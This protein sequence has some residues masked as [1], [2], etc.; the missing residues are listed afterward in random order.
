MAKSW[1][2]PLVSLF[3]FLPATTPGSSPIAERVLGFWYWEHWDHYTYPGGIVFKVP[4][5]WVLVWFHISLSISETSSIYSVFLC[6]RRLK[7]RSRQCEYTACPF[8]IFFQCCQ[9]FALWM[10]Y[11]VFFLRHQPDCQTRLILQRKQRNWWFC[12]LANVQS[13]SPRSLIEIYVYCTFLYR[14][15]TTKNGF[16]QR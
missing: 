2:W 15:L 9:R 3:R 12:R 10:Y 6:V 16:H 5:L 1:W 7:E 14:L 4:I 11:N 8:F 13:V